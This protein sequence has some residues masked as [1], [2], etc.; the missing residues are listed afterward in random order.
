[1]PDLDP[2]ESA[3]TGDLA[4]ALR[5]QWEINHAEHCTNEWPHEDLPNGPC[6]WPMPPVLAALNRRDAGDDDD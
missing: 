5:E 2:L 4:S 6:Y 1:M 3:L